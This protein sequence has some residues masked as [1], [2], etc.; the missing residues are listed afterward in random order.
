MYN[1]I[2]I[3]PLKDF[4]IDCYTTAIYS[5]LLSKFSVDK[6][7]IY[8]N[9]YTYQYDR[10]ERKNL[11]RVYV[12]MCINDVVDHLLIHKEVHNFSE[13]DDV[14][15][16]LKYYLDESK[17]V[18]LGIDMFY[19]IPDT[20]Q[21]KKHHVRHYILVEG[22]DD[23]KNVIYLLE[24]GDDG[25]KEYMLSYDDIT[26]ASKNFTN[27]S[28]VYDVTKDFNVQMYDL[29]MLQENAKKIISSIHTVMPNIPNI[30]IVDESLIMSMKDEIETHLKSIMN[31]QKVNRLLF[32]ST[33]FISNPDKYIEGFKKL[34]LQSKGLREMFIHSCMNNQYDQ[35]EKRIKEIFVDLLSTELSLWNRFCKE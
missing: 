16:N 13:D 24:T 8:N 26:R 12:R 31:R 18:L 20:T 28:Y 34:E 1:G 33:N 2:K 7:F 19:G 4:W 9:C 10:N 14:I 3:I 11:G 21:W 35:N 15:S 6:A 23:E 30:W 29:D 17:I 22:Y 25:Y 5:I 32:E 27:E